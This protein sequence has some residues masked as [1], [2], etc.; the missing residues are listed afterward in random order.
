ML[1][2]IPVLPG[3]ATTISVRAGAAERR[4]GAFV[5]PAEIRGEDGALCVSARVLLAAKRPSAPA[6]S[7]KA[8][9]PKY[10]RTPESA[11][12]EVLFHGPDMRFLLAVPSCGPEGIVVET[13]TAPPPSS[14]MRAPAR[15]RWLADPAALDAL[16]QAMILWSEQELGAPCLPSF[17]GRYRQFA[18]FP[19]SGVRIVVRAEK[20][21][22]GSAGAD[23]EFV[24]ER[25]ALVARL[26]G[27][28]CAVSA[29]LAP[30]FRRNAVE[31]A[32]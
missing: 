24:D 28:E 10:G 13:K 16:F 31:S 11:Y 26:D 22:G 18:E 25:G 32:A 2:A 20:R 8:A 15:D 6:P 5:V 27:C 4:D 1:K 7:L 19:E 29:G 9:G 12:R 30:A 14:W 3:R 21:A 23:A 17:A